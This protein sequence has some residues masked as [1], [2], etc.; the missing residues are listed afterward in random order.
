MKG[1]R[2]DI[3]IEQGAN[4]FLAFT[5][6][7]ASGTPV[8]FT[9]AEVEAQMREF[10]ESQDS[11]SFSTSHNAEGGKIS[12]TMS[13]SETAEIGFSDGFYDVFTVQDGERKKRLHGKVKID[14]SVTR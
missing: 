3:T 8:D 4:F 1:K 6:K 13:P 7:D 12:L 9:G 10:P 14:S 11:Y 2:F 5:V